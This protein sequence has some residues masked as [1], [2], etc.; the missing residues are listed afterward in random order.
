MSATV[1]CPTT[2]TFNANGSAEMEVAY[3]QT[4]VLDTAHSTFDVS[5]DAFSYF[6]LAE[7]A[8]GAVLGYTVSIPNKATFK[9]ALGNWLKGTAVNS[10]SQS[11]ESYMIEYLR[12]E[13]N[14]LVGS[15]G[16]GA[17]LEAS[18]V[19]NLAFTQYATDAQGGADNLIDALDASQNHLNAIGLQLPKARYLEDFSGSLPAQV[20]DSLTFQFTISS[21]ITVSDSQQDPAADITNATGGN[22]PT[23]GASLNVT[24]S[25]IVHIRA[26]KTS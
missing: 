1:Y 10:S 17:A 8:S 26:N 16:V 21:S 20:G 3:M 4:V 11:V 6:S 12:G 13:I 18:A 2:G 9:T 7:E 15:D 22:N 25:R 23:I 19:K 5:A 24:K 14:A